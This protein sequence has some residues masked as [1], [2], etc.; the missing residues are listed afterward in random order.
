M[1]RVW[2]DSFWTVHV[3]YLRKLVIV[4]RGTTPFEDVE[5]IE[6]SHLRLGRELASYALRC[7]ALLIDSRLSPKITPALETAFVAGATRIHRLFQ[8]YAVIVRPSGVTQG[9]QIRARLVSTCLVTSLPEEAGAHLG[10]PDLAGLLGA[11][12]R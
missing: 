1:L 7:R 2:S 11:R 3:E 6:S 4:E 5:T 8:V 9:K 10:V 12:R